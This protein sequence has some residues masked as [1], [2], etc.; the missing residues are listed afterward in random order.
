MDDVVSTIKKSFENDSNEMFKM[1]VKIILSKFAQ[2]LS[3]V[4]EN[5]EIE[6]EEYIDLWVENGYSIYGLFCP[7]C[8]IITH[9]E[10]LC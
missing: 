1:K 3:K 6:M 7:S 9:K 8:E 10:H 2:E 4:P 5:A